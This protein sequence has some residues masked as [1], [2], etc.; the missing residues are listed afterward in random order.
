[1]KSVTFS[2]MSLLLL[3]LVVSCGKNNES[4]KSSSYSYNNPLNNPYGYGNPYQG[5][6]PTYPSGYPIADAAQNDNPCAAGV[7]YS[8]QRIPIQTQMMG[9]NIAAGD[10]YV[11]VTSYGDV[12]YVT[13][14]GN[15]TAMLNAFLC[16]RAANSGTGSITQPV[17][18]TALQGCEVKGITAMD[19]R[20]PDGQVAKFRDPSFGV[21]STFPP[22]QKLKNFSFCPYA[23]TN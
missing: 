3:S 21:R 14:T 22:Y 8:N 1:M 18:N 6:V 17:L 23:Q 4:G 20:F 15:R 13:G 12:A 5:A 19:I 16:P 11:G 7:Y 9:L 10:V 2:L